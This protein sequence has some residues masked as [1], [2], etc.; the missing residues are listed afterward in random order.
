[1]TLFVGSGTFDDDFVGS[2][3]LD[4]DFVGLGTLKIQAKKTLLLSR[5]LGKS[6]WR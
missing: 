4:N 5:V 2:G 1:M 3:M 6:A